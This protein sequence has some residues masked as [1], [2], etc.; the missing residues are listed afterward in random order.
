MRY[1][2]QIAFVTFALLSGALTG[3]T[4]AQGTNPDKPVVSTVTGNNGTTVSTGAGTNSE[5]DPVE[6]HDSSDARSLRQDT[7]SDETLG[8]RG[9][10]GSSPGNVSKHTGRSATGR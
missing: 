9:A 5:Q 6:P 3:T 1:M 2:P 7:I 4:I 8:G 10:D